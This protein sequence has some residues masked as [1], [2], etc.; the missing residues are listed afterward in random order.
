MFNYLEISAL[1]YII[2]KTLFLVYFGEPQLVEPEENLK[3]P[4]IDPI[5]D[6]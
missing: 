1:Y 3:I 6:L 5:V 4:T 2:I